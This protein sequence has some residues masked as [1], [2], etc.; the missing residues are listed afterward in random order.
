MVGILNS[1]KLP[2]SLRL[3]SRPPFIY[4]KSSSESLNSQPTPASTYTITKEEPK[5]PS[6]AS[7]SSSS[8]AATTSAIAPPPNFKVP[9]PKRFAIRPDKTWDI[10]GSTLALFFRLG[11]GM[12]VSGYGHFLYFSSSSSVCLFYLVG[13]FRLFFFLKKIERWVISGM[14]F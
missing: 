9:E 1:P 3:Q 11:T 5:S 12:F 7:F 2:L 8:S 14:K 6:F 10:V 13:L 4:I